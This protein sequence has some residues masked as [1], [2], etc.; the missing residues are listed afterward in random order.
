[1][2]HGRDVHQ[3]IGLENNQFRVYH[4]TLFTRTH[5]IQLGILIEESLQIGPVKIVR[6]VPIRITYFLESAVVGFLA[7]LIGDWMLFEISEIVV[8]RVKELLSGRFVSPVNKIR[9]DSSA[10]F[11]LKKKKRMCLVD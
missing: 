4:P 3:I 6:Q 11:V 7:Q 2:S 1:M 9:V 10:V 8:L 5:Q